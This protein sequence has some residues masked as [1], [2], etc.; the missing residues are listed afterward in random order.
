[1]SEANPQPLGPL[2]PT[3]VYEDYTAIFTALQSHACTYGFAIRQSTIKPN[4]ANA[5]TVVWTCDKG[6]KYD[7][8]GKSPLLDI[9]RKRDNTASKKTRCQYRVTSKKDPVT[10]SWTVEVK[11]NNHNHV[12]S[13]VSVY[14]AHRIALIS[15]EVRDAII[16]AGKIGKS[17]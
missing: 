10:T 11:V 9:S 5:T 2:F 16:A 13:I 6:G 17:T 7:S 12:A 4:K 3:A 14:P 8:R 15:K 1:M